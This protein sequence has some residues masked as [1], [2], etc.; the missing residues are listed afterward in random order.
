MLAK[1]TPKG[2]MLSANKSYLVLFPVGSS[3]IFGLPNPG[4]PASCRANDVNGY[5]FA[6]H[7]RECDNE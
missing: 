7:I 1:G 3:V 5:C 2:A 6:T 4:S